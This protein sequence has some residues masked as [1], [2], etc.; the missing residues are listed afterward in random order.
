MSNYQ[1][2][3]SIIIPTEQRAALTEDLLERLD[4]LRSKIDIANEVIVVDSSWGKDQAKI[5]SAC[6]KYD[7]L[8]FVGPANVRRKR[9]LGI[10][11][12]R[13][14]IIL[15][16]DSDCIPA[17]GLLQ[18]HWAHYNNLD[19]LHISGV[20]GHTTFIGS[21]TLAWKLVRHSS[22][23]KQFDAGE[24][25]QLIIWGPTINLSVR[26]DVLD[27][28][29]MFDESFPFKLGGDDLDLTYRLTQ[30]GRKLLSEPNA[31]V[32]HKLDTWNSLRA[33]LK[34][35][36]RWGRMEYHLFRKHPDLRS[37]YPPTIWGWLI[38]ILALSITQ[39]IILGALY[40]MY[41][42]LLWFLISL[43]FFSSCEA[44]DNNMLWR[45]RLKVFVKSFCTAIPELVYQL[46]STFEFI[47]HADP[48]FFYS[49][50]LL[51]HGGINGVWIPE[52]WNT[53][54]N[55]AALILS[56]TAFLFVLRDL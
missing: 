38:L 2:G 25:T 52:A 6:N 39:S 15:F 8:L 14:S 32:Y 26:R 36:F 10:S 56:Q 42:P 4:E 37:K 19:T 24:K 16:L 44:L 28:I 43:L 17:D 30:S 7:A 53:W 23:L 33:V 3:V 35:A 9:N 11:K 40:F 1:R 18:A 48:R 45:D 49:R 51:N 21:E 47:K 34:R 5:T 55:L 12:S 50:V 20:L 27:D 54:S 31:I 13:Y 22:L 29:G 41:L 46:G